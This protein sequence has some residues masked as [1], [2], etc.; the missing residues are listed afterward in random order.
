M[1][2]IQRI[3]AFLDLADAR[4]PNVANDACQ[5]YRLGDCDEAI[6]LKTGDLRA[7]MAELEAIKNPTPEHIDSIAMRLHHGFGLMAEPTKQGVRSTARQMHEES[8]LQGFYQPP[9]AKAKE[10]KVDGQA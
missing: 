4:F 7:V 10:G 2:H 6:S 3:Q 9:A 5:L 8:T 1:S